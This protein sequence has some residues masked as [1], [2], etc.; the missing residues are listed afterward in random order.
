MAPSVSLLRRVFI[1]PAQRTRLCER[2]QRCITTFGSL[3]KM[4]NE[5]QFLRAFFYYYY[6]FLQRVLPGAVTNTTDLVNHRTAT[7]KL[8]LSPVF[9]VLQ[10]HAWCLCCPSKLAHA[11]YGTPTGPAAQVIKDKV[12]LI[13]LL[14]QINIS[15]IMRSFLLLHHRR[16]NE[17]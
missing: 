9:T 10:A 11:V 16:Q 5:R 17:Y 1:R 8:M 15:P 7:A 4:S 6:F 3:Q 13:L 12:E 2:K 14:P